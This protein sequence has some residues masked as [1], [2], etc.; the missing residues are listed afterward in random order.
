MPQDKSFDY[1]I[2]VPAAPSEQGPME[3][4]APKLQRI[5]VIDKTALKGQKRR[6]VIEQIFQANK[7]QVPA[8]DKITITRWD[9]QSNQARY[10]IG[11]GQTKIIKIDS[12]KEGPKVEVH[13]A[14]KKEEGETTGELVGAGFSAFLSSYDKLFRAHLAGNLGTFLWWL[15]IL[16]VWAIYEATNVVKE[17]ARKPLL[18]EIS[19]SGPEGFFEA[20]E[21]TTNILQD[22][23]EGQN[24]AVITRLQDGIANG[25]RLLEAVDNPSVR[26]DLLKQTLHNIEGSSKD[27]PVLLPV[28]YYSEN[29]YHTALLSIYKTE[30]GYVIQKFSLACEDPA[31]PGK[32]VPM[33]EYVLA[34]EKDSSASDKFSSVFLKLIALQKAPQLIAATPEQKKQLGA[35]KTV[36]EKAGPID[37]VADPLSSILGTAN[38]PESARRMKPSDDPWKLMFT[39]INASD[40]NLIEDKTQ[41][42]TLVTER[43]ASHIFKYMDRLTPDQ[44]EIA[45][46]LLDKRIEKLEGALR[47][48]DPDLAKA[49]VAPLKSQVHEAATTSLQETLN[50]R[51]LA[52]RQALLEPLPVVPMWLMFRSPVAASQGTELAATEEK[53]GVSG[54]SSQ[55]EELERLD[56]IFG[57]SS[58][59]EVAKAPSQEQAVQVI[60]DLTALHQKVE[61]LLEA[62]DYR[63]AR[64]AAALTLSCLPNLDTPELWKEFTF[65]QMDELSLL[66]EKTS[67]QLLEAKLRLGD[68][69]LWPEEFIHVW[70]AKA[71][72]VSLARAR[73]ALLRKEARTAY[74]ENPSVGASFGLGPNPNEKEWNEFFDK[75]GIDELAPFLEKLNI[76]FELAEALSF[77]D[78]TLESSKV[79]HLIEKSPYLHFGDDPLL[80]KK[81]SSLLKFFNDDSKDRIPILLNA[82]EN[83]TLYERTDELMKTSIA[84]IRTAYKKPVSTSP[85]EF[86]KLAKKEINRAAS[87]S[88]AQYLPSFLIDIRR[89]EVWSDVLMNPKGSLY[90]SFPDTAKGKLSAFDWFSTNLSTA[91]Q[92]TED[93]SEIASR[94]F[95]QQYT[96]IRK[97]LGEMGRLRIA[98]DKT[99][100]DEENPTIQLLSVSDFIPA[101]TSKPESSFGLCVF[102]RQLPGKFAQSK[103]EEDPQLFQPVLGFMPSSVAVIEV[104]TDEGYHELIETPEGN[105]APLLTFEDPHVSKKPAELFLMA[106]ESETFGNLG[107]LDRYRVMALKA[108]KH[109]FTSF[110][111]WLLLETSPHLVDNPVIQNRL[112]QLLFSNNA[113]KIHLTLTSSQFSRIA[114][115]LDAQISDSLQKGNLVRAGFL[116]FLSQRLKQEVDEGI[117]FWEKIDSGDKEA[118]DQLFEWAKSTD[119]CQRENKDEYLKNAQERAKKE[120]DALHELATLLPS[121]EREYEGQTPE[122]KET[123]SSVRKELID[124]INTPRKGTDLKS[125]SLFLL[126]SIDKDAVSKLTP[127]EA[128]AVLKAWDVLRSAQTDISIPNLRQILVMRMEKTLLPLLAKRMGADEK[129][130]NDLLNKWAGV[131]YDKWEVSSDNH[132]RFFIKGPSDT[133]EASADIVTCEISL[134]IASARATSISYP[135]PDEIASHKRYISLFGNE[136]FSAVISA[137]KNNP[138]LQECR[139]ESNGRAFTL[140]YDQKKKELTVYQTLMSQTTV[141]GKT[142]LKPLEFRY[143]EALCSEKSNF[144]KA[145][146]HYGIWVNERNPKQ[147]LLLPGKMQ[148]WKSQPEMLEDAFY[149]SL[150]KLSDVKLITTSN[151][152]HVLQDSQHLAT[153]YFPFADEGDVI[154]L[155]QGEEKTIKR[156]RLLK[157]KME[158]EVTAD[159]GLRPLD[160]EPGWECWF[161]DTKP[162]VERFGPAYEQYMIALKRGKEVELRLFPHA[163]NPLRLRG[164]TGSLLDF[165]KKAPW[166]SSLPNLTIK[167][168]DQ[169][170]MRGSHAG[171]LYLAYVAYAR[172][173]LDRAA[174]YLEEA[175]RADT[176]PKEIEVVQFILSMLREQPH[177]TTK[178]I[179]FQLKAEMTIRRVLRDYYHVPEF[180]PENWEAHSEQIERVLALHSE[181]ESA[182][183]HPEKEQ[184]LKAAKLLLTEQDAFEFDRF[185]SESIR[186]LL[187]AEE[188][189]P[190][191]PQ[192]SE[193]LMRRPLS[194]FDSP[195]FM[196]H[197][198]VW[199]E[200]PISGATKET[201][202]GMGLTPT[203]ENV[204]KHFWT[205]WTLISKR[206][207]SAED[208]SPLMLPIRTA[209]GSDPGLVE[210]V[211]FARRLLFSYARYAEGFSKVVK[212]VEE[213]LDRLNIQ[214]QANALSVEQAKRLIPEEIDETLEKAKSEIEELQKKI[215][216]PPTTDEVEEKLAEL[217]RMEK[218]LGQALE[219]LEAERKEIKVISVED[220]EKKELEEELESLKSYARVLGFPESEIS[221]LS[222]DAISL[223]RLHEKAKEAIE[224]KTKEIEGIL[225][226]RE[227]ALES[228]Q[229]IEPQIKKK[230]EEYQKL[231]K[232]LDDLKRLESQ[233]KSLESLVAEKTAALKH[234]KLLENADLSDLFPTPSSEIFQVKE[235]L[236]PE[237][238]KLLRASNILTTLTNLWRQTKLEK[239]MSALQTLSDAVQ[240]AIT[241]MLRGGPVELTIKKRKIPM[242]LPGADKI[243]P[244]NLAISELEVAP[245]SSTKL[246]LD[247]FRKRIEKADLSDEEKGLYLAALNKIGPDEG[248]HPLN[249][250]LRKLL[251]EGGLPMVALHRFNA[252]KEA[253]QKKEQSPTAP[254][255]AIESAL[256]LPPKKASDL[257]PFFTA[258]LRLP[259]TVQLVRLAEVFSKEAAFSSNSK[260]GLAWL[261]TYQQIYSADGTQIAFLKAQTEKE[262][263]QVS[264]SKEVAQFLLSAAAS[265]RLAEISNAAPATQLADPNTLDPLGKIAQPD[266]TALTQLYE[267]HLKEEQKALIDERCAQAKEPF[268]KVPETT[269]EDQILMVEHENQRFI[270]GLDAAA[271]KKKALIDRKKG[272]IS[273]RQV[274]PLIRG[275]NQNIRSIRAA[276]KQQ[277][278]EI[279]K[280]FAPFSKQFGLEAM[281]LHPEK[282]TPE[283]R[284]NAIIDLCEDG[285]LSSEIKDDEQRDGLLTAVSQ[286]LF[287]ATEMQQKEK[288]LDDAAK[289]RPMAQRREALQLEL[290]EINAKI[291]SAGPSPKAQRVKQALEQQA[292]QLKVKINEIEIEWK[293]LSSSIEDKIEAGENH[294]R[295]SDGTYRT[296]VLRVL[297][298]K[299]AQ[300][301]DEKAAVDEK[302]KELDLKIQSSPPEK[303]VLEAKLGQ[304]RDK[305]K[306]LHALITE[307]DGRLQKVNGQRGDVIDLDQTLPYLVREYRQK[308]VFTDA[309]IEKIET[310]LDDPNAL[311]EFRM[312]LGKSS[313]IFPCVARILI[314]RGK[315]PIV[316]FTEELI[317]QSRKDMDKKAYFFQFSR[318]SSVAPE[319]LAEEY[320]TLL[321]VKHSKRYVITTVE[322]IAALENKVIELEKSLKDM[323]ASYESKQRKD[324]RLFNEMSRTMEQ[325]FWLKKICSVFDHEDTRIVADEIDE[326]FTIL[327][328]KN[329]SDGELSI[330][331][332][333]AFD[334]GE[335]IFGYI[336]KSSHPAVAQ[337]REAL[338]NDKLSNYSKEQVQQVMKVLAEEIYDDKEFWADIGWDFNSRPKDKEEFA[339]YLSDI[340]SVKLPEGMAEWPK[341]PADKSALQKVAAIG[342]MRHWMT[343]TLPTLCEKQDGKD[344]GFGPDGFSVVPRKEQREK[345]NTKFG[346]E[347]E[348]IGYHFLAY[349]RN[350]KNPQ[351][352]AFFLS[353]IPDIQTR[354]SKEPM[355]V[356]NEPE[357]AK[358]LHPW[359]T[360]FANLDPDRTSDPEVMLRNFQDPE[361]YGD[362]MQF[363]RFIMQVSPRI[364]VFT[365]QLARNVQD[366]ILGRKVGG[367]AGTMS[368]YSLPNQFSYDRSK[369]A[370]TG[371]GDT[372][373]RLAM[374]G[375]GFEE[376]VGVFTHLMDQITELSRDRE[377]KA[378]I[379]QGYATPDMTSHDVIRHLRQKELDAVKSGQLRPEDRRQY[380]YVDPTTKQGYLWMPDAPNPQPFDKE[381]DAKKISSDH[382]LYYFGPADTRGTDFKIPYGYGALIVGPTTTPD[383]FDQA[384]WRLR[385]LGQGQD[386]KVFVEKTH[387]DRFAPKGTPKFKDLISDIELKGVQTNATLNLKA[388]T[389][390]PEAALRQEVKKAIFAPQ[391]TS[392][393]FLKAKQ[394][395]TARGELEKEME[396][397][398][399]SFETVETLFVRSKALNF[400]SDYTPSVMEDIMPH[401]DKKY[402]KMLE[403]VG[404][405]DTSGILHDLPK[406]SQET[407]IGSQRVEALRTMVR[408]AKSNISEEKQ[409]VQ[410][411]A[412]F[413]QQFLQA[414]V[415]S[416]ETGQKDVQAEVQEQQ[417]QQQ[418]E[419]TQL[420]QEQKTRSKL[421]ILSGE[422]RGS[423]S[424]YFTP[425]FNF[426]LTP[427]VNPYMDS[428][429]YSMESFF[430]D[431]GIGVSIPIKF[432]QAMR[433][434]A[435]VC[436]PVGS[437]TGYLVTYQFG[438]GED[439]S[440]W[441]S[442]WMTD[443]DYE[444][445][446]PRL[447]ASPEM[448]PNCISVLSLSEKSV[449]PEILFNL[450]PRGEGKKNYDELQVAIAKLTMGFSA[451]PEGER[452]KLFKWFSSLEERQKSNWIAILEQ[453]QASKTCI[454][455]L[456]GWTKSQVYT[457]APTIAKETVAKVSQTAKK[458]PVSAQKKEAVTKVPQVIVQARDHRSVGGAG[459]CADYSM[460]DQ[461]AQM[462]KTVSL[463]D[464]RKAAG[465]Y[466]EDNK[467]AIAQDVEWMDEIRTAL[468]DAPDRPSNIKVGEIDDMNPELLVSAYAKYIQRS[469]TWWDSAAFRA[470]V[471]NRNRVMRGMQIAVM[472]DSGQGKYRIS[473]YPGNEMLNPEKCLF[474]WYNQ[475]R[476]SLGNHYHSFNRDSVNLQTAVEE[477]RMSFFTNFW[478]RLITTE[479]QE[480]IKGSLRELSIHDPISYHAICYL[481]WAK[482]KPAQ[483]DY[484]KYAQGLIDQSNDLALFFTTNEV[485]PEKIQIE[486]QNFFME[487]RV[488]ERVQ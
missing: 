67:G 331:N 210:A 55:S 353:Q 377:C 5:K 253:I 439:S 150:D 166:E 16:P 80:N 278:V 4:A 60:K 433:E 190:L 281:F 149:I 450:N 93:P 89:H 177:A 402:D 291:S 53:K 79:C 484:I 38:Q 444:N 217:L 365:S 83:K 94:M 330:I 45:L 118:L 364:Q 44:R 442:T 363:L 418:Q 477:H 218:V 478:E 42:M 390:R 74:M 11:S 103:T 156:V 213:E 195:Q 301:T 139:F 78:Y 163:I 471:A 482:D 348:L 157:E 421:D 374:M 434:F 376:D 97:R 81:A 36:S 172:G 161:Y 466:L 443:L 275:L 108:A 176:N 422:S 339:A 206:Q 452:R 295:F 463:E 461:L 124:Q 155:G 58:T 24:P 282:Y 138:A 220:A 128:A 131:A 56:T 40:P 396:G 126:A 384:I 457:P 358:K 211:D 403:K 225:Q 52:K 480:Q 185:K 10:R 440:D 370:R 165:D 309:Q 280:A 136:R 203:P 208:L 48:T 151:G 3:G 351:L 30:D 129:F 411:E 148:E 14:I 104:N 329:F 199:M 352:D 227:K 246:T 486:R 476:R 171:F 13:L 324:E 292:K 102:P 415:S 391:G 412:E 115:N 325:L 85:E 298:D 205:Y 407:D 386:A 37:A 72:L 388:A 423:A 257:Q 154:F 26:D 441:V 92:G 380:I 299:I 34:D 470:L 234:L 222:N 354:A 25:K 455:M 343:K 382:V 182:V 427:E 332:R 385:Q 8:P 327:S 192:T 268:S 448:L 284:L 475:S 64:I 321:S 338:I 383:E 272:Y 201:V 181:Y 401:L 175:S 425:I 387:A 174:L 207:L 389:A 18:K 368:R 179:A 474:I 193:I 279:E 344:Y 265:I 66:V 204:L 6:K 469:N 318:N 241:P 183:K 251:T 289:L 373:L 1:V 313:V 250:L 135:I 419:Q 258:D 297:Q 294:Q 458:Q 381:L 239:H 369:D 468:K 267:A 61:D 180:T 408:V 240:S 451:Y 304:L 99:V 87:L 178:T 160:K 473:Q 248:R 259:T 341:P 399:K 349:I 106:A 413:H 269:S 261:Q 120:I 244:P 416:S 186:T 398:A 467:S 372:L 70:N 224:E 485:D 62:Q 12:S 459:K 238:I 91:S 69:F 302:I 277:Q 375:Q 22:E 290:K 130:R 252:L 95:D 435:K 322:R 481:I 132:C 426:Y 319:D 276:L 98:I 221:E 214:Q 63:K 188:S 230:Q 287:A 84:A 75:R 127:D 337:F 164:Q 360:W 311:E 159:G 274:D 189:L 288:A 113:L 242:E 273:D 76:R 43:S 88:E 50:R 144:G 296:T 141:K 29:G 414:K 105:K 465:G 134:A 454:E 347:A 65:E 371:T 162:L 228:N 231:K 170:R 168:D 140:V 121:A 293:E 9:S 245:P 236:A 310:I 198:I 158:F 300:F 283:E 340:E 194:V 255:T 109:Y 432:T 456:K 196:N 345:P 20:L 286:Y 41:F 420:Q 483:Q 357:E 147:A 117:Y 146:Q 359:R 119:L 114:L 187:E 392:E 51:D 317:E 17:E 397:T 73:Y 395:P 367:A 254:T 169:G 247:E 107:T 32:L 100:F 479:N 429:I 39:W 21:T 7:D 173:D 393:R 336:F 323:W 417:Q 215:V 314:N 229:A 305:S 436:P 23:L 271:K 462:R 438:D 153:P 235:N 125:L 379:N 361:N 237:E 256:T 430:P 219:A 308:L 47:K 122:T 49:I 378:I 428:Y 111:V 133:E 77:R 306:E 226:E 86:G 270:D 446:V 346:Q 101:S 409:Q 447:M 400:E 424:E 200:P 145:L 264:S 350:G 59:T 315:F 335:K 142:V 212:I 445:L 110:K 152:M 232:P 116:T 90:L 312:G 449:E 488:V 303:E 356:E 263:V 33:L 334:S 82:F 68:G 328:E 28:G 209:K 320:H 285:R 31:H 96:D 35:L 167:I 249:E 307:L 15:I 223:K 460:R 260:H 342:A 355:I 197:L 472:Q 137:S 404:S 233:Q 202:L 362:R 54:I 266:L 316:L 333:V 19:P 216:K 405:E 123:K 394:D 453:R 366:T 243:L 437:A 406:P 262:P 27:A 71:V 2:K 431:C 410:N 46:N 464:L 143:S 326:I 191:A 487:D 184:Q 57:L 112:L